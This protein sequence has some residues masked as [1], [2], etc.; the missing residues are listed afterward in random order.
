MHKYFPTMSGK[1]KFQRLAQKI[2]NEKKE[3]K[4]LV[5]NIAR[6]VK[7]HKGVN[8]G[9]S[10]RQLQK[11]LN[12]PSLVRAVHSKPSKSMLKLTHSSDDS[13]TLVGH[14]FL[15]SMANA[16]Y[17]A[18]SPGTQLYTFELNPLNIT[19][20]RLFYHAQMYDRYE[21]LECRIHYKAAVGNQRDG[22]F[23]GFWDRDIRDEILSSGDTAL[24]EIY[25][26][27]DAHS[28]A[29]T[30]DAEWRC[31]P[32]PPKN[33]EY[34]VKEASGETRQVTQAKFFLYSEVQ[35]DLGTASPGTLWISYK[36]RLFQPVLPEGES[37]ATQLDAAMAYIYWDNAEDYSDPAGSWVSD[38][39]MTITPYQT[40][41]FFGVTVS[42]PNTSE[43]LKKSV[44]H[45]SRYGYT[46]SST[47]ALLAQPR[48]WYWSGTGWQN[49]D[50][51]TQSTKSS[52]STEPDYTVEFV[53][54][55]ISNAS[56]QDIKTHSSG[57]Q[58]AIMFEAA[59]LNEFASGNFWEL[60]ISFNV[61]DAFP[62]PANGSR[63][64]RVRRMGLS[65]PDRQLQLLQGEKKA[66]QLT[67]ADDAER[68]DQ[69]SSRDRRGGLD[70]SK[71]ISDRAPGQDERRES[72]CV[73]E[74][75]DDYV[76]VTPPRASPDRGLS[77][78]S[79][80]PGSSK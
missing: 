56:T 37:K 9:V 17:D 8:L 49:L 51:Y 75:A 12:S 33:P 26:H 52:R 6:A 54:R 18:K 16:S 30:R 31:P 39:K 69:K 20:S 57:G 53:D 19:N 47:G 63:A 73:R 50:L 34:Y 32:Q 5:K 79:Q 59:N 4:H 67:S 77:A 35:A 48:V 38:S 11:S 13:M 25:A 55:C 45:V 15:T 76:S 3:E 74:V 66:V 22:A 41:T 27:K 80:R 14:D 44:F 36:I 64:E 7:N 42:L 72:A 29:V 40:T 23:L 28:T 2:K 68:G 24:K 65:G 71:A 43:V 21:F 60:A 62:P 58:F 1:T 61:M 70:S 46:P 10:S 78:K